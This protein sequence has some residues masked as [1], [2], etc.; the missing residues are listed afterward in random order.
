VFRVLKSNNC[1]KGGEA[2]S[3][4]DLERL[5]E[6]YDIHYSRRV[7]KNPTTKI[8]NMS[9]SEFGHRKIIDHR[10]NGFVEG[11]E[12]LQNFSKASGTCCKD[13]SQFN[14]IFVKF[15]N[16]TKKQKMRTRHFSVLNYS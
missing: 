14:W 9:F 8:K 12:P 6:F 11:T 1:N 10:K 4:S 7:I 3:I 5:K 16:N 15:P 2:L 13:K